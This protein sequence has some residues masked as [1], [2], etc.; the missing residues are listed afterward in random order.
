M[1][2]YFPNSHVSDE[3]V[4]VDEA[5]PAARGRG[6]EA[7]KLLGARLW[8]WFFQSVAD[9]FAWLVITGTNCTVCSGSV[10]D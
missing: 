7:L 1:L 3:L 8:S 4:G 6:F 9:A 10:V 5:I 2:L